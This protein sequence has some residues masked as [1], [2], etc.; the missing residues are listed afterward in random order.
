M[1]GVLKQ[2][3]PQISQL[4]SRKIDGIFPE[5]HPASLG[6][7]IG[8]SPPAGCSLEVVRWALSPA[9]AGPG[10][11]HQTPQREA[12]WSISK[13]KRF[14]SGKTWHV[15]SKNKGDWNY[16]DIGTL[17]ILEY[18]RYVTFKNWDLKSK[19]F[20]FRQMWILNS[21]IK[22]LYLINSW[23]LIN[24]QNWPLTSK[25]WDLTKKTCGFQH[26]KV[27]F[28]Q[29][30]QQNLLGVICVPWESSRILVP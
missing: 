17:I 26:R 21:T 1:G 28:H 4:S 6:I 19:Q 9:I 29:Q 10:K 25:W 27:G 14:L 13:N 8:F 7:S 22:R 18:F 5:N 3:Y 20:R 2:G 16:Q 12:S 11:N 24:Q 23:D 15:R 30:T